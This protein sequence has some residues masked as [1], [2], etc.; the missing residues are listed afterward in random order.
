MTAPGSA[1]H[2]V[3]SVGAT[4]PCAGPPQAGSAPS[5]GSAV[6]AVTSVGANPSAAPGRPKQ[7]R[8]AV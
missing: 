6:H 3:T 4:D 1:V 2:A 5:G 7:A 8:T